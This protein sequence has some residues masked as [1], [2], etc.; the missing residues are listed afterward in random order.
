MFPPLVTHFPC[1]TLHNDAPLQMRLVK[2]FAHRR[3]IHIF[4]G[5]C[6]RNWRPGKV[7][8]RS[9]RLLAEAR[10]RDVDGSP[11]LSRQ[12]LQALEHSPK[13]PWRDT[14]AGAARCPGPH[15]LCHHRTMSSD[16][17][18]KHP[19]PAA[20]VAGH[21]PERARLHQGSLRPRPTPALAP[22]RR[23]AAERAG[24]RAHVVR[25]RGAAGAGKGGI[26]HPQGRG[27]CRRV[28]ATDAS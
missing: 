9:D 3:I 16:P 11:M 24:W 4:R 27:S 20:R 28:Y 10:R 15:T 17:S 1:R 22:D 26:H 5:T 14:N 21:R 19:E 13:R 2:F 6:T 8:A 18:R 25:R 12:S 23:A 7:P